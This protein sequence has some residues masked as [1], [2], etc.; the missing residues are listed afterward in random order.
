MKSYG[1][2]IEPFDKMPDLTRDLTYLSEH[3]LNQK[4]KPKF[5]GKSPAFHV[6]KP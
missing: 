2:L 4:I 3:D 5:D 1:T 6:Q